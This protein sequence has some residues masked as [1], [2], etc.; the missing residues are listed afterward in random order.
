[1]TTMT[2]PGNAVARNAAH[3]GPS[4]GPWHRFMLSWFERAVR[5]A[6]G[7]SSF[8]LPYWDWGADANNPFGSP[9]IQLLGG[10]G[11]IT[12]GTFT[13]QNFRVNLTE[14]VDTRQVVGANRPMRRQV[15]LRTSDF[16]SN[17]EIVAFITPSQAYAQW[18]YHNGTTSFRRSLEVPIHNS[19]HQFVGGDMMTTTSPNDPIFFLHHANIDRIWAAWQSVRGYDVY[20][21]SAGATADCLM[22]RM[23][24]RLHTIWGDNVTVAAML[25]HRN[26][27][28]YDMLADVRPTN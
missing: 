26:D 6:I 1:M 13:A 23:N 14:N 18:P 28:D 11:Q 2:P 3:G 22:H 7:D 15:G 19:I 25:D 8:F 27:Y 12:G 5:A 10:T 24:D 16:L 4:F 9:V 17:G 21:P 20:Q